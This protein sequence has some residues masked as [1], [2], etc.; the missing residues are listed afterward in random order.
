MFW[1]YRFYHVGLIFTF[2]KAMMT[3]VI[4]NEKAAALPFSRTATLVNKSL[5]PVF[6]LSDLWQHIS[7]LHRI[8]V[9][10][11]NLGFAKGHLL[12][13]AKLILFHHFLRGFAQ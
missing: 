6:K 5:I 9:L 2:I 1:N 10:H 7:V 11:L 8:H 3:E 13:S 4:K 12:V